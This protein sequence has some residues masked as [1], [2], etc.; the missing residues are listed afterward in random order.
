MAEEKCTQKRRSTTRAREVSLSARTATLKG[1]RKTNKQ[2]GHRLGLLL[3]ARLEGPLGRRYNACRRACGPCV[4]APEVPV[5]WPDHASTCCRDPPW[6]LRG[7]DIGLA[8]ALVG[9]ILRESHALVA[10]SEVLGRRHK[11]HMRASEPYVC[12]LEAAGRGRGE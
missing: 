6:D 10:F 12:A 8:D 9:A 7:V 11:T 5:W 3:W 1:A 2:L 4:N